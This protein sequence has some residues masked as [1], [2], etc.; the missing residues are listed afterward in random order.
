MSVKQLIL[1]LPEQRSID[2]LINTALK[3][4]IACNWEKR[5]HYLSL[6]SCHLPTRLVKFVKEFQIS[7]DD[8]NRLCLLSN[9]KV[10]TCIQTPL[11][12][13]DN[14][15]SLAEDF[16]IC[17]VASLLGEVFGWQEEQ[18]GSIVH[19][20]VP[21]KHHENAQTSTG[22]SQVIHWHT[23][24][25]FHQYASDYLALACIKNPS[26][27]ATTYCSVNSLDLSD[28][29]FDT[30]FEPRFIFKKVDS[31]KSDMR[32]GS[33][34][35]VLYGSRNKPFIR[36]DYYFMESIDL[37]ASQSLNKL[38]EHI[39]S[40]LHKVILKPGDI[41]LLDNAL[42]IHGRDPF[43]ANYDGND[44]W[45]KRVNITRDLYKSRSRGSHILSRLLK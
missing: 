21:L 27:V 16:L 12:L 1:E 7:I 8:I 5:L 45:L 28:P 4:L 41:L 32:E 20:I 38:I 24:E 19:D 36:I 34:K 33:T 3:E 42:C 6:L 39:N 18:N 29:I 40:S 15:Y 25:A 35:S 13:E 10:D 23:D 37:K 26:Q 43:S 22:S 17:T 31:H 2:Y 14:G 11:S 44:R 30:L 9:F